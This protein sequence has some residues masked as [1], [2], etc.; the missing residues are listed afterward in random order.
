[1]IRS[2]A[3]HVLGKAQ[4]CKIS[5]LGAVV[6]Q[7]WCSLEAAAH[8]LLIP[9]CPDDDPAAP[10]PS[11]K[12][13][14][15]EAEKC[16]GYARINSPFSRSLVKSLVARYPG[17]NPQITVSKTGAHPRRRLKPAGLQPD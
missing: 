13:A 1:M 14:K 11:K 10:S 7:L 4:A 9:P 8:K 2:Y 3:T 12:E 16:S 17:E 5:I 15:R 6:A